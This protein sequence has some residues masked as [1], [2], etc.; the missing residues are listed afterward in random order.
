MFEKLMLLVSS[1]IGGMIMLFISEVM[2]LLN[3]LLIIMFMV[4]LIMLLCMVNFLNFLSM[5]MVIFFR[6]SG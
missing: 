4:R 6:V 5:F 3:V 2:I 1:L